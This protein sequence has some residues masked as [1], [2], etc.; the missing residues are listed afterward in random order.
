VHNNLTNTIEGV[1][2]LKDLK[3]KSELN[4]AAKFRAL[5]AELGLRQDEVARKLGINWATV[6]DIEKARIEVTDSIIK[7]L[8]SL[9]GKTDEQQRS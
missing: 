7:R 5:R 6:I 9:R 4:N 2:E 1:N 3:M 8:E